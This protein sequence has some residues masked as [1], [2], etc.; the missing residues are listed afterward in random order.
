MAATTTFEIGPAG[1][2]AGNYTDVAMAYLHDEVRFD[3][4]LGLSRKVNRCMF[5]VLL[6]FCFSVSM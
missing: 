3:F 6:H 2:I 5:Y 1:K 4:I